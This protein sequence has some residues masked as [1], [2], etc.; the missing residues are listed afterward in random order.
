[1][2]ELPL[3]SIVTPTFERAHFIERTIRSVAGQSYPHVEH[4]VVDGASKDGTAALL[5]RCAT[6]YNLRWVSEPDRG[7][8]DAINKGLRMARGEIVAYLNSDDLY[9]PWSVERVVD[10]FRQDIATDLVYGDALRIDRFRRITVPV[11]APLT[12]NAGW[13]PTAR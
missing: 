4:I 5:E 8:Y 3:V 11:F 6:Q 12:A 10:A 1:M 2:S 13:L 9:F 7:M